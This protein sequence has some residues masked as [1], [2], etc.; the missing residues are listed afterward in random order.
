L[1]EKVY[2]V[3][4]KV[5]KEITAN[6]SDRIEIERFWSQEAF[7]DIANTLVRMNIRLQHREQ[8]N[9]VDPRITLNN[10][11]LMIIQNR[12]TIREILNAVHKISGKVEFEFDFDTT[13]IFLN[14]NYE[15]QFSELEIESKK[16]GNEKK[17]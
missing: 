16:D 7:N 15:I 13:T 1:H 12:I 14:G 11:G 4:L 3:T 9:D 5:L 10:L 6:Y 2:K 17:T 8:S